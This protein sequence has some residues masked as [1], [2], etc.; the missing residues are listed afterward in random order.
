MSG[1]RMKKTRRGKHIPITAR[2]L[3][4]LEMACHDSAGHRFGSDTF[5]FGDAVG[6]RAG[7][8]KKAWETALLKAHGYI[9]RWVNGSLAPESSAA[10]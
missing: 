2:L 7:S 1:H 5:V 4:V 10:Y 9:P 8:P 3:A 6:Q